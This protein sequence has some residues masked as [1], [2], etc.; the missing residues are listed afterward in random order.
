[1]KRRRQPKGKKINPTFFVFCEGETEESYINFLKSEYRIPSIHI[2]PRIGR[3]NITKEYIENYKQ[4]KPTHEKDLDF[5][6]YDIDVPKM[7]QRLSQIEGCILLVS[8]PSVE[9]W[10]LLHYKN[11]TSHT[12]SAYCCKEL[13]NRN[14]SYNKGLIDNKLKEKLISKRDYAIKRAKNLKEF[15]N[16]STTV[17]K[18]I[19]ILTHIA[20]II[21]KSRKNRLITLKVFNKSFLDNF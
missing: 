3:N 13:K 17:Y 20:A 7:L 18:V 5:L 11:H 6:F 15:E 10:F 19:E 1:M 2:H 16:P 14:H 9:L 12:N 21:V 4:N 8:N